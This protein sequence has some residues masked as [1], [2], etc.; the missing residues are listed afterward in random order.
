VYFFWKFQRLGGWKRLIV[1]ALTLGLAQIAKYSAVA[2]FPLLAVMAVVFHA[3]D[4]WREV[5]ERQLDALYR[6]AA[7]ACAGAL[8]FVVVSLLVINAGYLFS[9][10]LT[11][12]DQYPFRSDPLRSIQSSAGAL[13]RLPLPVPYP[14]VERL[15]W[16]LEH[17]R[18]GSNIGRIYLLGELREGEGFAGYYFY[19]SVFKVPIAT[20]LVLLVAA[21]A[22]V[23]RRRRFDLLRNEAVLLVPILFFTIYFNFFYRAQ[24][25]I[26]HFLVVFPLLYVL[27]GSLLAKGTA[28]TRP[29]ATALA[30]AVATLIVSVLSYYPHFL[31]YF[32]E[33]VWDRKQAYT[34]LADSNLDWGQNGR[35]LAEYQATHPGLIDEP[36]TP[37]AGTIL[38]RVNAL[39][40]VI[41]DPNKFRWLRE[42]FTPVDHVGHATLV[43]RISNT[44]L[45]RAA[46]K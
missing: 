33:L 31:A 20:Q 8:V 36:D 10:T 38:V 6:R 26:R 25:G 23:A 15:D 3:T 14:Y 1:S 24:I 29:M 37:T 16:V 7:A 43:Y 40:G 45:E 30:A 17:E 39:I 22:F 18:T 46:V 11:P 44:D 12:L 27:A 34:V 2:L 5:R 4:I 19:A 32:N 41:G 28:V 35:D 9:Q 42:H 13:G 21:A